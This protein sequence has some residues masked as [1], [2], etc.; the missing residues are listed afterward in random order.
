MRIGFV[1]DIHGNLPAFKV[2]L[3]RLEGI[4]VYCLGDLVGY[5]PYPNE[6]IEIVRKRGINCIMGNHDYAVLTG[7]VSNFSYIAAEAVMWT[8]KR[9][10]DNNLKFLASLPKVLSKR[11]F[12]MVHGSPRDPLDEYVFPEHSYMDAFLELI[13]QD[14]LV[15]GHTH[16]PFVHSSEKGIIFNPGAVGQP[17]DGDPRASY[18]IFDTDTGKISIERAEY[19]INTVAGEIKKSGLPVALADRL[20]LGY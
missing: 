10:S 6:V 11:G 9:T 15:M 14:I 20:F 16:V 7:D 4:E 13:E 1:S 12:Y 5:N 2:V 17:R 18:A 8:K 3:E 19:D